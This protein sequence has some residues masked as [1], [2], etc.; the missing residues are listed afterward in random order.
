MSRHTHHK[1]GCIGGEHV[2]LMA[3]ETGR[4]ALSTSDGPVILT[5]NAAAML[6][7]ALAEAFDVSSVAGVP[8]ANLA[9]QF[10]Q[11]RGALCD[12]L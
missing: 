6:V 3:L 7:L 11:A 2:R 12:A 8:V 5:A 10:Q 9:R 4:A 1:I